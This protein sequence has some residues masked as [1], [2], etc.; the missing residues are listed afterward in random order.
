MLIELPPTQTF[1]PI[2]LQLNIQSQ[3]ELDQL[4]FLTNHKAIIET[5]TALPLRELRHTLF[6]DR[7]AYDY[8]DYASKLSSW[9]S[10]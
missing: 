3:E 8:S 9:F 6:E 10:K 5:C 4:Y 2:T 1:T 7:V